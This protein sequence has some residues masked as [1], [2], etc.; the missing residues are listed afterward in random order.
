MA[1]VANRTPLSQLLEVVV[2]CGES[3]D[4]HYNTAD[5][6][7]SYKEDNPLGRPTLC[8]SHN[9]LYPLYLNYVNSEPPVK[10]SHIN[11]RYPM[12]PL[13]QSAAG[14]RAR[15]IKYPSPLFYTTKIHKRQL[16]CIPSKML[17]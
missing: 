12:Q 5:L 1:E 2:D 16:K 8:E 13:Q 15:G 9:L 10:V 14:K 7:S 6:L 11:Y 3:A 17:W 4:C